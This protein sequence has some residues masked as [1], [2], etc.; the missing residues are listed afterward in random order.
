M[1]YSS[2]SSGPR[3]IVGRGL[4]GSRLRAW[5]LI[6]G[7]LLACG[8]LAFADQDPEPQLAKEHREWLELVDLLITEEE[9]EYFLS[10]E[11]AFRR[12]AFIEAF[13]A[14]RD[15]FD[16]THTNELRRRWEETAEHARIEFGGFLDART[17]VLLLKGEPA[18][19]CRTRFRELEDWYYPLNERTLYHL[20][21]VKNT[22]GLP[23]EIWTPGVPMR[24]T[25]RERAIEL[26][27]EETCDFHPLLFKFQ[28]TRI[29]CGQS[30]IETSLD[31]FLKPPPPPSKEWLAT[32]KSFTTDLPDGVERFEIGFDSEYLGRHQSRT[33]LQGLLTVPPLEGGADSADRPRHLLLTGEVI[34]ENELFD[35]FRYRYEMPADRAVPLVFQRYLRP[36]P[37]R[38]LLKV[39]DLG[40]LRMARTEVEID[41]PSLDEAADVPRLTDSPILQL[42][43]EAN[44]ATAK[45]ESIIRLIPPPGV[46]HTGLVRFNTFTAGDFEKVRFFLDDQPLMAKKRPPYSVE[47]DLGDTPAIHRLRVHAVDENDAVVA[48]DEILLNPGGQRFR[49]RLIEPRP[50]KTYLQSVRTVVEVLVPDGEPIDRVEL[51]LNEDRVATLYQPPFV[52]PIVLPEIKMTAYVRAVAYL[53]DGNATEDLVFINAPDFADELDVQFVELYAS[54]Y[55]DDGHPVLGL[56]REDFKVIE[57]EERQD[58]RRFEWV[59][60]LPI[61]AALMIDTSA[62]MEDSLVGVK[63]AARVFIEHALTPKDRFALLSFDSLPNVERRFTNSADDLTRTLD[64]L[65][66]EG[67]TALYD[68]LVFALHY[69]A[70]VRGQKALLLLSDGEDES[71][72]FDF[73]G[74]LE[75]AQRAGVLIYTIGLKEA[76]RSRASRKVLR[77]LAAETGGRSFFLDDLA[78]LKR[79]YAVI[80][81]ELR[82]QYLIAY[83]SDS[84]KDPSEFRR[85]EVNVRGKGREVRTMSGYYP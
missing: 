46:I 70:G 65:K 43:D 57:D 31:H 84:S 63:D 62:S 48:D 2:L 35:T 53:A 37:A 81:Q 17:R 79:I 24:P 73:E 39:E 44:R 59:N 32:F 36:G 72:R 47:L 64:G 5:I 67:G 60:N 26:T 52:Q 54:V 58:I 77:Q 69:F 30:M 34:R 14:E 51:F 13:W 85:V 11:D 82:T 21:L 50:E 7:C 75:Y 49:T 15:P 20:T 6:V 12:N 41:V 23:Y 8:P 4:S 83:Q 16:D 66:A 9:R 40:S 68:S 22:R 71:S 80:N 78:D 18:V 42:L 76:S 29:C 25:L 45:G 55:D 56:T 3:P 33:V 74:A 10:I 27:L 61:H 19:R 1:V 38:L 28:T